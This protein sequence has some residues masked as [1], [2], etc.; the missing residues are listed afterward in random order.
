MGENALNFDEVGSYPESAEVVQV[1]AVYDLA[2]VRPQFE[3][4]RKEAVRIA[5]EA[6]TIV[7]Q[8]QETLNISVMLGGSAKK[9]WKAVDAQRK[10]IILEPA[11]FVKG[12]NSICKMLA[13]SLDEAE[14]ITKSKIGQH[15]A[16]V[17]MERREAERKAREATEQ[18]QRKLQQEAAESNW[19]AAQEAAARAEAEARARK[20]SDAEIEQAKKQAEEE[21]AKIAVVAPIVVRPVVQE[22]AK[23]TRTESGSASQRKVWSFEVVNETEVPREYLVVEQGKIRDAVKMGTRTIPGV[24]IYEETKTIFRA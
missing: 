20:A 24:R 14:R 5:S 9:I 7:V 8:D 18:L 11:E 19:K 16:R 12:V 21:A 15:Q 2:V 17:E 1:G 4:Y 6:G 10:A 23:V 13:D 22:A 3:D